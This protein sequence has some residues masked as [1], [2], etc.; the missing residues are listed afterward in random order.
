MEVE[1]GDGSEGLFN[2]SSSGGPSEVSLNTLDVL[3][4]VLC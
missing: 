2:S 3:R 1:L 4:D